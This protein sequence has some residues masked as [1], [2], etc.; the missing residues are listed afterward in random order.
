M[1]LTVD[2]NKLI[3]APAGD[4]VMQSV[5]AE[6]VLRIANKQIVPSIVLVARLTP[7]D[8][9]QL[10]RAIGAV[11]IVPTDGKILSVQSPTAHGR[12]VMRKPQR[13]QSLKKIGPSGLGVR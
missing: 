2:G 12:R 10:V 9:H 8:M 13:F 3:S 5:V 11:E 7:G 6:I 1:R 4:S